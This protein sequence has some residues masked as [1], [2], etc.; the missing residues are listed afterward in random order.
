MKNTHGSRRCVARLVTT[1]CCV[2]LA[3]GA[4]S[5][6]SKYGGVGQDSD[7]PV[8]PNPPRKQVNGGQTPAEPKPKAANTDVP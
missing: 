5:C 1:L 8:K 3:I 6:G 2:T 7:P 4:V